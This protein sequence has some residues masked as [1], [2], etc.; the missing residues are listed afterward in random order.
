MS[1]FNVLKIKIKKKKSSFFLLGL[2]LIEDE[3]HILSNHDPPNYGVRPFRLLPSITKGTPGLK[4]IFY[5]SSFL[6]F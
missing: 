4:S 2:C 6:G 1:Q 5:Q 3:A